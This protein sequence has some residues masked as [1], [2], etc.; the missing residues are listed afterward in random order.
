MA[1]PRAVPHLSVWQYLAPTMASAN[2]LYRHPIMMFGVGRASIA[3]LDLGSGPLHELNRLL[4]G[5]TD[6]TFVAT[7]RQPSVVPADV[8]YVVTLDA[9]RSEIDHHPPSL[10]SA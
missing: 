5:A 10:A 1:K 6:T 7:A 4:H 9:G 3:A 2:R 8:R